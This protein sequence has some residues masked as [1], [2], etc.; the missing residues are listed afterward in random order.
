MYYIASTAG[1]SEENFETFWK[2]VYKHI[3]LAAQ[4][5]KTHKRLCNHEHDERSVSIKLTTDCMHAI[6]AV[7]A[8]CT[9]RFVVLCIHW[10]EARGC[11]NFRNFVAKKTHL[12]SLASAVLAVLRVYFGRGAAKSE[13]S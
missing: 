8:S 10:V 3:G 12:S 13:Y 9:C 4:T 1:E 5:H 2:D 7:D 6:R 11:F